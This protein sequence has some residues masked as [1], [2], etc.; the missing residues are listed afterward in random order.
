MTF[1]PHVELGW[2]ALVRL[3]L[4]GEGLIRVAAPQIVVAVAR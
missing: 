4:W 2:S 1:P 3:A